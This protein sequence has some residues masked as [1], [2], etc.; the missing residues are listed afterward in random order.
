MPVDEKIFEFE[1]DGITYYY[2]KRFE[3]DTIYKEKDKRG[4]DKFIGHIQCTKCHGT[5]EVVWRRDNGICYSC[6]GI[7]YLRVNLDVTKNRATAERRLQA[8]AVKKEKQ[9]KEEAERCKQRR[10]EA[11]KRNTEWTF[12]KYTDNF[13]IILDTLD[14]S[15]YKEREYIKSKGGQWSY[16]FNCWWI[17]S[18]DNVKEDFKD[19]QIYELPTKNLLTD[20][21]E[22][23]TFR[24]YQVVLAYLDKLKEKRGK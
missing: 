1:K 2:I 20:Y 19:F 8:L 18:N 23:D 13:Y 3:V 22:L 10:L 4:K 17:P 24:V 16:A 5:G 12:K 21:G 9:Q 11:I 7:G 14:K 6:H 15:T